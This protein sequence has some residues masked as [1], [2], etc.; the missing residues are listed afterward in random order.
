MRVVDYDRD[1][2]MKKLMGTLYLFIFVLSACNSPSFS[3][4]QNPDGSNPSGILTNGCIPPI[5]TFAYPANL[6]HTIP[7]TTKVHPVESDTVI[8]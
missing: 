3:A 2:K 7:D 5:T 1:K 6:K 8:E 4:A